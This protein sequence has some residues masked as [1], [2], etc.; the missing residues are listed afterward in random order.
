MD[1]Q[2]FNISLPKELVK[3]I[4]RAAK[5]DMGSRSEYFRRLALD[6]LNMRREWEELFNSANRKGQRLGITSEQQVY[7]TIKDYKR[8][9]RTKQPKTSH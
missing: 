2:T 1:K 6:D 3:A 8:G 5:Q 9:K 4:D 7:D